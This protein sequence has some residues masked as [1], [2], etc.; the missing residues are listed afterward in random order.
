MTV[1]QR[2]PYSGELVFTAFS[3]SHQDAIRKGL[4]VRGEIW[5]VPYLT[6]DPQDIGR[7][8]GNLIRVNG[9]SGKG[10]IAYLLEQGCGIHLPKD[11]V[12]E[13]SSVVAPSIDAFGREVTS[14]D[15]KAMMW[16][17]YVERVSPYNLHTFHCI[18]EINGCR[19]QAVIGVGQSGDTETRFDLSGQG[20]G[21]IDAFI[22]SLHEKGVIDVHILDQAEHSLGEGA[23]ASAIAYVK[24]QFPDGIMR[25]GAGVD[26]SIPLASIRAV[27]SALNRE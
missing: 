2:Q 20:N 14:A 6:I 26:S 23:E 19:F 4:R 11:M 27:I 10:G 5:E 22:R 25:W 17:E 15:L 12:R 7:T 16:K 9:Q 24:L 1:P 21:P 8:Y 3:G 18:D 13:F